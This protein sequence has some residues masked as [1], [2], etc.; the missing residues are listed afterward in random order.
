M[1]VSPFTPAGTATLAVTSTTGSVILSGAGSSVEVQNTGLVMMFIKL[2]SSTV[3]AAT[4]DYPVPAGQSKVIGRNP[5]T[6]LYIA[7]I[8][9][10][11]TTTLYATTGEGV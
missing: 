7:A 8:T 9:A 1:N 3:T 5:N 10:S 4:T 2:G 11:G 6:D